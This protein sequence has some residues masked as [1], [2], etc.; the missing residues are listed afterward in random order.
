MTAIFEMIDPTRIFEVNGQVCL[1]SC[2]TSV[3][4]VANNQTVVAAVS[5]KRIRGM[6]LTAQSN[7]DAAIAGIALKSASG[8]SIIYQFYAP[9]RLSSP[10]HL[11]IAACGYFETN[12]GEGLY[13][14]VSTNVAILNVFYIIYT[15]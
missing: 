10:E 4:T 13:V 5:G 11:P 2:A 6:G 1:L 14:D 12:T 8:G 15:P 9:P 3:P 7:V